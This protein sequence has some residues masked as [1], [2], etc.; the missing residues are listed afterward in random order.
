MNLAD[1]LIT[2]LNELLRLWS[3]SE[4]ALKL[5]LELK[6]ILLLVLLKASLTL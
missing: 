6:R 4:I 5:L 2:L 1:G 3:K